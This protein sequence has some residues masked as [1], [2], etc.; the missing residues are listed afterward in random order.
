MKADP[1]QT[2]EGVA[3]RH[4][5]NQFK[6]W[7]EALLKVY[8]GDAWARAN[9]LIAVSGNAD[10]TSG[11]KEAADATLREEIEKAA[12]AIFASNPKQ[13]DFWLGKGAATVEELGSRYGGEKPCIWGC[14]AHG[15]ARVGSPDGD[16]FC[17]IK[18]RVTFDALRQAVIDPERAYVGAT[19]PSWASPSQIIDTIQWKAHLGRKRRA[20]SLIRAS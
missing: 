1:S 15:P 10:G 20:S 13:R 4:G 12:H 2:D 9:I 16:R 11:V 19:P 6:V 8:Q 17:W 3:L 7:R 5:V 14:D 18:G